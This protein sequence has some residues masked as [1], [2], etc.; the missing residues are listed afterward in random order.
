MACFSGHGKGVLRLRRS[1]SCARTCGCTSFNRFPENP[2]TVSIGV[3]RPSR[4]PNKAGLVCYH[5][6]PE[7]NRHPPKPGHRQ[8]RQ[9]RVV[10]ESRSHRQWNSVHINSSHYDLRLLTTTRSTGMVP[11]SEKCL[12]AHCGHLC[13]APIPKCCLLVESPGSSATTRCVG[14]TPSPAMTS[15]PAEAKRNGKSVWNVR[16][17]THPDTR[18]AGLPIS[19]RATT[20]PTA[21]WRVS[22]GTDDPGVDSNAH[23]T[24]APCLFTLFSNVATNQETANVASDPIT[25]RPPQFAE[26]TNWKAHGIVH[27]LGRWRDLLLTRFKETWPS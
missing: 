22:R 23:G 26:W 1:S 25:K 14:T 2:F 12:T 19:L 16:P 21:R 8:L 15:Y 3:V 11:Q 6:D 27:P 18:Y 7:I 20:Y 10:A 24:T 17:S 9:M 4:A 13:G 5:V